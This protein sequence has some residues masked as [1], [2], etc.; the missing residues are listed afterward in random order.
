MRRPHNFM[1]IL[2]FLV[3]P[4]LVVVQDTTESSR[5]RANE[6]QQ[7]S[8]KAN[9]ISN[10]PAKSLMPSIGADDRG[11]V[12]VAWM[13]TSSGNAEILYSMWNGVKWSPPTNVSNTGKVSAFPSLAL[14]DSGGIHLAWMEGGRG[15]FDIFHSKKADD[16]WSV[17]LESF[18]VE[19]HLPASPTGIRFRRNR[20]R[21]LV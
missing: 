16:K 6:E 18:K 20:T 14:D 4:L 21:H 12:H 15:E 7:T 10:N 19:G 13:D 2:V 9:N 17:P 1:V 8:T 3:T 5:V 11:N